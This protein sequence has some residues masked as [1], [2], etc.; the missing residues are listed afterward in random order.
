MDIRYTHCYTAGFWQYDARLARR[1][2]VD[3]IQ[4]SNWS[5][6]STFINNPIWYSDPFGADSI[7]RSQAIQKAEEYVELNTTPSKSS[8]NGRKGKPGECV[9]CSGLVS[10][11]VMAGGEPNPNNPVPEGQRKPN[12]N[13][14][15]KR[16]KLA[17]TNLE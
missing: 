17:S 16:R 14:S 3:P 5:P 15:G 8:Y 12:G 6:Y 4:H 10:N 2:N 13:Q 9:D 11:S 1:W 7:Q